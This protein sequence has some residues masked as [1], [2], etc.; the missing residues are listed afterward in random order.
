MLFKFVTIFVPEAKAENFFIKTAKNI[1]F[2]VFFAKK[3]IFTSC[4][5]G[6]K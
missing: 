4:Y 6:A 5:K 3:S 2:L 1:K